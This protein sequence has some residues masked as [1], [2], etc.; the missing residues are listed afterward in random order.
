[1][2]KIVVHHFPNKH[3]RLFGANIDVDV[4][5]SLRKKLNLGNSPE[6]LTEETVIQALKSIK[7]ESRL[8]SLI[9]KPGVVLLSSVALMGLCVPIGF[10]AHA[11][12]GIVALAIS[13]KVATIFFGSISCG[14]AVLGLQILLQPSLSKA[15][16]DQGSEAHKLIEKLKEAPAGTLVIL[17]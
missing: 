14:W 7:R 6:V 1:M 11:A 12:I 17:P 15:Y 4:Q 2:V 5:N 9:S 13:L 3:Y 16:K 8:K 10:A